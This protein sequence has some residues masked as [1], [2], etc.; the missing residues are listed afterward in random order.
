MTTAKRVVTVLDSINVI[1]N[2]YMSSTPYIMYVVGR[3]QRCNKVFNPCHTVI[4][5]ITASSSTAVG[6][7]ETLTVYYYCISEYKAI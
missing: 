6:N 2:N 3:R 7:D 1:Q 4:T 5:V